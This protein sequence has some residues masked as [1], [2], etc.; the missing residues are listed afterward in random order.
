[1]PD[2]PEHRHPQPGASERAS[3]L[4]GRWRH[5]R[6]FGRR[7]R[8]PGDP[9]QGPGIVGNTGNMREGRV[10]SRPLGIGS[11][12]NVEHRLD[13]RTRRHR[14]T[15]CHTQ[16]TSW[17]PSLPGSYRLSLRLDALMNSFFRSSK[18]CTAGNWG[19]SA[20]TLSGAWNRM[21]AWASDSMVVSL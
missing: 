11:D 5:S 3:V 4:L 12:G 7:G 9:D 16:R 6:R 19:N 18:V 2:G 8:V 20:M 15:H 1:R 13:E 10:L 17:C 21:P 14:R